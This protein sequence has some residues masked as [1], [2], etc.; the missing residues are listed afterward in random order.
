MLNINAIK[1][2]A[3][4][5]NSC[6]EKKNMLKLVAVFDKFNKE[7]DRPAIF[8]FDSKNYFIVSHK[9]IMIGN[10]KMSFAIPTK[11]VKS[12]FDL[13]DEAKEYIK[14]FDLTKI[15]EMKVYPE[16]LDSAYWKR[17]SWLDDF[18]F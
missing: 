13:D 5:V 10:A 1:E 3:T 2:V 14:K 11:T 7:F 16:S 8:G 15:D 4:V 18:A 12:V 6:E 17:I 9:E